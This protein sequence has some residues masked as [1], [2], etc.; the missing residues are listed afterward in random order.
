MNGKLIYE[1][2]CLLLNQD[3]NK[4]PDTEGMSAIRAARKIA[5][6]KLETIHTAIVGDYEPDF[7]SNR[8]KWTGWLWFNPSR[9]AFV[10]SDTDCTYTNSALGARFWF[11]DETTARDFTITNADLINDLH[12]PGK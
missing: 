8:L 6:H 2:A 11:P 10:C 3:P 5:E 7:S 1:E 9:G 4:L 12:R